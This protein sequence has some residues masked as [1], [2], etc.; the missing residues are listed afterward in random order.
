LHKVS[1]VVLETPLHRSSLLAVGVALVRPETLTVMARVATASVRQLPVLLFFA[2][3]AAVGQV[4]PALLLV[5]TVV[6]GRG[7]QIAQQSTQQAERRTLA[8]AVAVPLL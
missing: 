4:L 5:A 7:S 3:A 6:A 1:A 8:V 2:Q